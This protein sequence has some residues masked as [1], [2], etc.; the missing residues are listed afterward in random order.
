MARG[1]V[2]HGQRNSHFKIFVRC[3]QP[4]PVG[5]TERILPQ[6]QYILSWL[7]VINNV[8]VCF[9]G[10]V[11]LW[12][13]RKCTQGKASRPPLW[14]HSGLYFHRSLSPITDMRAQ[15]GYHAK[16]GAALSINGDV[17]ACI[18]SK[19]HSSVRIS[20]YGAQLQPQAW[21]VGNMFETCQD[22]AR[23]KGILLLL[24]SLALSGPSWS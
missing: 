13:G 24:S 10:I 18:L 17:Y 9:R 6:L 19:K 21:G 12:P 11:E 5:K 14:G 4:T 16:E 1:C 3:M 15:R 2:L 23:P 8:F 20:M 7:E 22:A